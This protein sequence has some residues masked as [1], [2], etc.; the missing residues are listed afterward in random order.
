MNRLGMMVDLSHVSHK[1]MRDVVVITKSPVMFSHTACYEL[2]RNYR[3]AP[4]DVLTRFKKNGGVATTFFASGFL[5]EVELKKADL[6][7]AV[8]HTCWNQ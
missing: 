3:N 8:D 4:D 6:E 1:T 7:T 2:A 5:N